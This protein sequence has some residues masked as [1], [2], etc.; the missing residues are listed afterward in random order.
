MLD[1]GDKLL[2]ARYHGELVQVEEREPSPEYPLH[3]VAG[4]REYIAQLACG[5]MLKVADV[6]VEGRTRSARHSHHQAAARSQKGA[7][8]ADQCHGVIDMLHHLRA[9]RIGGRRLPIGERGW[10]QQVRLA[11]LG[12]AAPLGGVFAAKRY[13]FCAVLD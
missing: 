8:V 7:G 11:K 13:P 9:D 10:L 5:E 1:V 4:T 6:V 2:P 12:R 3:L